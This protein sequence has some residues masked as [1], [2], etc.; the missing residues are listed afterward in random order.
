M[1]PKCGARVGH[2]V[3]PLV[4]FQ[5]NVDVRDAKSGR[6]RRKDLL[7]LPLLRHS[8]PKGRGEKFCGV[9]S[10]KRISSARYVTISEE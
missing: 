9:L 3:S 6:G 4:P 2:L 1:N 5:F 8:R 7:L 10:M